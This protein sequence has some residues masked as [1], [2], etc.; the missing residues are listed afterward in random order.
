M[1]ILF[2]LPVVTPWWFGEIIAPMLRALYADAELHVMLAPMWRGT[3]IEGAQLDPLDDLPGINWHVVEGDPATFRT[4]GHAVEGLLDLVHAINPDLTLCRSAD[5]MTPAHFP[6]TV[7]YIM[8]GGAAPFETDLHW[9]VLEQSLF[10]Y[11]A[12]RAGAAAIGGHVADALAPLFRRGE[13][14]LEAEPAAGWRRY[15]GLPDDRNILLVPLQYE[16]EEDFFVEHSAFPR[17]VDLVAH[18]L[19]TVDE[20]TFLA[21]T[22]HPLNRLFVD[23]SAIDALIAANPDRARLCLGSGLPVGATGLIAPRA[24]AML[25]DQSKSWSLAAFKGTPI[26]HVGNT[27]MADWLGATR[28][29]AGFPDRLG[30]PDMEMGRRWFGWHLGTRLLEPRAFTLDDLMTRV[31]GD[32][33][34]ASINANLALLAAQPM[35]AAA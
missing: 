10:A 12:M 24:D 1:T 7:R 26:L 25:V 20:S 30:R 22:D 15:F 29:L 34:E 11:G 23:R 4:D 16:H 27:P 14:R 18:L 2:Y 21:V 5:Q 8:E 3:G 33:T 17:A 6:G 35:K 9:I 32:W 13:Q 19:R 28:D 31:A